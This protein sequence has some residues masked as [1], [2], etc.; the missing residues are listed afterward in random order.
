MTTQWPCLLKKMKKRWAAWLPYVP[1]SEKINVKETQGQVWMLLW[2][3]DL[4]PFPKKT[5]WVEISS[6]FCCGKFG[7]V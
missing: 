3:N 2:Q 7:F 4:W 5:Y 1:A 6:S